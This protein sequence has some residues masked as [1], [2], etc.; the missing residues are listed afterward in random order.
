[1]DEVNPIQLN[2]L[3][4]IEM[5]EN[6][7]HSP[8]AKVCALNIM[9]EEKIIV[10]EPPIFGDC[11]FCHDYKCFNPEVYGCCLSCYPIYFKG[12]NEEAID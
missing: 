12:E 4:A 5:M 1:M 9:F 8:A 11:H 6:P 2:I 3:D 7:N 10:V